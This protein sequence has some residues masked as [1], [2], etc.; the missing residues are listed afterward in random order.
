MIYKY[1]SAITGRMPTQDTHFIPLFQGSV[2]DAKVG[3]CPQATYGVFLQTSEHR[4]GCL[5]KFNRC[6][7]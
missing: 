4:T 3:Y 1:N 6:M 5:S 2:V 7:Q